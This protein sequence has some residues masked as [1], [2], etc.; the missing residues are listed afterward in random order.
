MKNWVKRNDDSRGRHNTNSQIKFETSM[1]KSVL[2][3]YSDAYIL[4][5]ETITVANTGTTAA[6]NNIGKV[7]AK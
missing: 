7:L 6:P 4:V 3:D 2:C 1:L 5:K